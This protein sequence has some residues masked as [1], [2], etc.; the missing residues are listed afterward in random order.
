MF[1]ACDKAVLG[2]CCGLLFWILMTLRDI[3]KYLMALVE[4]YTKE[5]NK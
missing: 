1:N 5:Q 3:A 4:K 2:I